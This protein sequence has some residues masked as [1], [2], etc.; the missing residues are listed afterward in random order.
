MVIIRLAKISMITAIGAY[1]LIVAYDN[2]RLRLKLRVCEARA[3]HGYDILPQ[4]V[5]APRYLR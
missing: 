2:R 3:E 1:A 5:D 4:S